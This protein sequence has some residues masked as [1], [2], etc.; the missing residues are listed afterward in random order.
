MALP[1]WDVA[2]VAVALGAEVGRRASCVLKAQ[3]V[4]V[5]QVSVSPPTVVSCALDFVVADGDR[6]N[7]GH[8]D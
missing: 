7:V 6:L 2:D 4:K 8:V 1:C 5:R 3:L